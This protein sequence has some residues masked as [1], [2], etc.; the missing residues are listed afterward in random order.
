MQLLPL[1]RFP[2][3][4]IEA[5]LD[6]AFGADRFGR[7]AYKVRQGTQPVD[8]LSFAMDDDGQLVGTIQCWPVE[9]KPVDDAAAALVMVGPVAVIP[10]RQGQYIGHALMNA[11]I[12]AADSSG[13][14][15]QMLIG[16]PEYYGRWDFTADRTGGWGVPGPFERHR[17][18]LRDPQHRPLPAT[19]MLGPRKDG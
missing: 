16:D 15:P 17:L 18:L 13:A 2:N 12:E 14:P 10:E 1:S 5:V 11:M 7:T 6:E 19:G 3:A 9:V 4:A 8:A